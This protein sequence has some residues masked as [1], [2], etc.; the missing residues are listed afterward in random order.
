MT[1]RAL[2][3]CLVMSLTAGLGVGC[4]NNDD[5][6]TS[7]NT[8]ATNNTTGGTNNTTGGTN[9]TTGG[10]TNNTTNNTTGGT[11]GGTTPVDETPKC[12]DFPAG[13]AN[14]PARCDADPGTFADWQ[15]AS[16][17]NMLA[18]IE[19]DGVCCYDY[20]GDGEQDNALGTLV[21]TLGAAAGGGGDED[22]FAQANTAIQD[23]ID[24]GTIAVVLE[25]DG[26]TS[27]DGGTFAVNFLLAEPD[28]FTKPDPT[29]NNTYK[30]NPA[31]FEAGTYPLARSE[32]ATLEGGKVTA[33]PGRIALALEL[34][35]IQLDLSVEAVYIEASADAANS[36]LDGKGVAL[37]GGKLAGLVKLQTV[38]DA[39]NKLG[40]D[41]CGCV[42]G[43]D[44]GDLIVVP[45][46]NIQD[47]A[48][49][50][51]LDGSACDSEDQFEGICKTLVENCNFV[52]IIPGLAD[53]RSDRLGQTC[54]ATAGADN[55]CDSIS[56][57]ANFTAAGANISGT[58]T[59]E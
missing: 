47:L 36:A 53:I 35:G 52:T 50:T 41:K 40:K 44:G 51:G 49:K 45:G 46:G 16:V 18:L 20:D 7:N 34:L 31:S 39:V 23:N 54:S 14:R 2:M 42:A 4:G 10:N 15:P 5:N 12:S 33:G 24:N 11:T 6:N 48:C 13:D 26:L 56:L 25:H 1:K 38:V 58:A 59:A 22:L 21:S 9:N 3:L 37:T 29:G 30:V 28:G 27:L 17:V 57:A 19:D 32:G 55:P 8:T 43:L